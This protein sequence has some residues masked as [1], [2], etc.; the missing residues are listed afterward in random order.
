MT[1]RKMVYTF[2]LSEN[3]NDFCVTLSD[4]NILTADTVPT[5]RDILLINEYPTIRNEYIGKRVNNSFLQ[6]SI[7]N[8]FELSGNITFCPTCM[9]A[10]E[11]DAI[12]KQL[13]KAVISDFKNQ[14]YCTYTLNHWGKLF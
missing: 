2:S 13:G 10:I 14:V 4:M 11:K 6:D 12:S 3:N 5:W 8:F 7:K 1:E 9:R